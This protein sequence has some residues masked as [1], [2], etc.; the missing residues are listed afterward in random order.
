VIDV[1]FLSK[2]PNTI[3]ASLLSLEGRKRYMKNCVF[4]DITPCGSVRTDVSE[5]LA[6]PS[7][8]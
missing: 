5:N 6:P 3:Y 7:S 8:G 4:W 2:G 1:F